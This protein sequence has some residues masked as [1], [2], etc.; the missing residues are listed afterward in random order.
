MFDTTNQTE[1]TLNIADDNYEEIF[2]SLEKENEN[3]ACNCNEEE[4]I[5]ADYGKD[6]NKVDKQQCWAIYF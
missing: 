2:D 6:N 3:N 5:F 4:D 1:T